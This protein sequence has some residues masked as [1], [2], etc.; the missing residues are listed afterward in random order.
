MKAVFLQSVNEIPLDTILGRMVHSSNLANRALEPV[1]SWPGSKANNWIKKVMLALK[2]QRGRTPLENFK[3]T[4]FS[5]IPNQQIA[6]GVHLN[7]SIIVLTTGYLDYLFF[8][9][10]HI[11]ATQAMRRIEK[12]IKTLN[13]KGLP[14]DLKDAL[15]ILT[16]IHISLGLGHI[17]GVL[18]CV[19]VLKCIQSLGHE[20]EIFNRYS[21]WI[22]FTLLHEIGHLDIYQRQISIPTTKEE[23]YCDAFALKGWHADAP[24]IGYA[25]DVLA[26]FTYQW[27]IDLRFHG[28]DTHPPTFLRAKMILDTLNVNGVFDELKSSLE[29]DFWLKGDALISRDEH[30]KMSDVASL[31][32]NKVSN[33]EKY[34][35]IANRI[36]QLSEA[37]SSN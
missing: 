14:D 21:N 29:H 4:Y 2:K 34:S 31:R 13:Q 30:K 10:T 23:L 15:K 22:L 20:S 19:D 18:N 9:A 8:I 33:I 36:F 28:Q 7:S 17:E 3:D 6:A 37:I 27:P 25:G 11:S 1:D 12:K 35:D 5:I 32:Y 26:L 16:R 24:L